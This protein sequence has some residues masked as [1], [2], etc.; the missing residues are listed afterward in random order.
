VLGE[1]VRHGE[2]TP[3]DLKRWVAASVGEFWSFPHAQLYKEPP[4]LAAAGLLVEQREDSGRRRRVFRATGAGR[5]VFAAWL[6]EPIGRV[7]ERRDLGLLKLSFAD[8]GEP[9]VVQ[10]LAADQVA[11][12]RDQL[13]H[14]EALRAAQERSPSPIMPWSLGEVLRMGLAYERLAV[15]F[16]TGLL[17]SPPTAPS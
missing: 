1:V 9:S 17:T 5:A 13:A 3:Y 6:A 8:L 2:A 16:W 7:G 4:R 15:E 11:A 14:Y 10:A 12:H